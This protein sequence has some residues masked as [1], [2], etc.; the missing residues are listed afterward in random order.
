MANADGIDVT[1]TANRDALIAQSDVIKNRVQESESNDLED[2]PV[3]RFDRHQSGRGHDQHSV[4]TMT[5]ENFK[6]FIMFCANP[7]SRT[8][9]NE[10]RRKLNYLSRE[11]RRQKAIVTSLLRAEEEQVRAVL[12]HSRTEIENAQMA[13]LQNVYET[14][15]KSLNDSFAKAVERQKRV[16]S[17]SFK[18]SLSSASSYYNIQLGR[19]DDMLETV[20]GDAI[21]KIDDQMHEI[22]SINSLIYPL[23]AADSML[24]LGEE[25]RADG[26]VSSCVEIVANN[27]ATYYSS[28]LVAKASTVSHQSIMALLPTKYVF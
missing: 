6:R 3:L 16:I 13:R 22:L 5:P 1:L 23:G 12:E 9:E 24:L 26:L 14:A 27:W 2:V 28:E 4:S 19:L 21:K 18:P 11:I 17:E 15:L 20:G 25:L 10:S 8:N 7:D